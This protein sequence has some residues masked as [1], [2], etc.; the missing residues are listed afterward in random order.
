MDWDEVRPTP[1][2]AAVFGEDLRLLPV[3]AQLFKA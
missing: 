2:K 3:A 1:Q